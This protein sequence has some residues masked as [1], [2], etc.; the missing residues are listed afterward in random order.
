MQSTTE[1]L[2]ESQP[3][4]D[5]ETQ[6]AAKEQEQK[7]PPAQEDLKVEVSNVELEGYDVNQPGGEFTQLL[8]GE[9]YQ[10]HFYPLIHYTQSVCLYQYEILC[11][12]SRTQV[13]D[14]EMVERA[15]VNGIGGGDGGKPD[16]VDEMEIS[17]E[18]LE[19]M[20]E[21]MELMECSD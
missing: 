6:T 21:L 18:D 20:P 17:D 4:I 19:G 3:T 5:K 12:F 8:R 7:D 14:G 11:I 15:W 2:Q 1:V 16:E 13:A 10:R 9:T